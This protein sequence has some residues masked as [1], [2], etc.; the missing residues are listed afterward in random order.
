MVWTPRRMS[1]LQ[2]IAAPAKPAFGWG[3]RSSGASSPTGSSAPSPE[4]GLWLARIEQTVNRVEQFVKQDRGRSTSLPQ[5]GRSSSLPPPP[6]PPPPP[7][8]PSSGMNNASGGLREQ[9]L[10][11][12][13]AHLSARRSTM[14]EE[15]YDD[16]VA[17]KAEMYF[18]PL[19]VGATPSAVDAIRDD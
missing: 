1:V 8:L 17:S 18:D 19:I 5:P 7:P 6:M 14:D 10:S 9:L 16:D 15:S 12:L 13:K 2:S 3:G 11:E 4:T